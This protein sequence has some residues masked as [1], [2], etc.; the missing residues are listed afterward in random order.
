MSV[1]T[2]RKNCA[3]H[4]KARRETALYGL[5]RHIKAAKPGKD[6]DR[7]EAEKVTLERRIQYGRD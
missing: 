2:S 3:G 5:E 7:M 1:R 4:V 6:L